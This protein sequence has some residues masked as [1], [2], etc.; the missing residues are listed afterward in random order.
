QKALDAALLDTLAA[1]CPEQTF[2]LDDEL[3]RAAQAYC[4]A[5]ALGRTNFDSMSLLFYAG[6]EA[7]YPGPQGSVSMVD[8]LAMADRAVGD[9]VPRG[10]KFDR[11]AVAARR[12]SA[13]RTVVAVLAAQ[14][15]AIAEP[16]PT[17][18]P[19]QTTLKLEGRLL[20]TVRDPKLFHAR[21]DGTVVQTK[22]P[23]SPDGSFSVQVG[24]AEPG[25]HSLELL[26]TGPAGP[27]L[28]LLRRVFV[29]VPPGDAPP[30]LALS[31]DPLEQIA[32]M[33]NRL[34][35]AHGLNTLQRD[36]ALD[37]IAL[38]HSTLMAQ[39]RTFAHILAADGDPMQ[40]LDRAGYANT[41]VGE[42]L[43]MGADALIAHQGIEGSPA[44]LANLLD[45]R[46]RR[47]GLG[48]VPGVAPEGIPTVYL[49]EVMAAPVIVEKDAAGEVFKVIQAERAAHGL[50]PLIRDPRL[51]RL[52]A[53]EIARCAREGTSNRVPTKFTERVMD[54]LAEVRS[55][56]AEIA[57]AG[58]PDEY[59]GMPNELNPGWTWAGVGAVYASTPKYG[60]G[61]LWMLIIYAR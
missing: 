57:V 60:P 28:A 55:V 3:L 23:A 20:D 9:I 41:S 21:P 2:T 4:D 29:G 40:R 8:S 19:E 56:T 53:D 6:R 1:L 50:Q 7:P 32:T 59:K 5:N 33:I 26:V 16:L 43:G 17:Q 12:I 25:E 49:T 39:T 46:H 51:D 22:L 42:N 52:A 35:R 36:K 10:C 37:A 31:G 13:Q 38:G 11:V 48:A 27:E 34:R 61:R 15:H 44:H 47:L 58:S 45:P 18:V 54:A 14:R 30:V 24:V